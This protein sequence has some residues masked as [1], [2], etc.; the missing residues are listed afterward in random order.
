[1]VSTTAGAITASVFVA[2]Y[3]GH[4]IGDHIVQSDTVMQAK[5]IPSN[6]R[7]AAGANPWTGWAACA[8]HVA[9]YTATQAA[10][11]LLVSLVAPLRLAGVL[12]A[13]VTSAATHAVIDR[14][15]VVAYVI[16]AK[17]CTDW[18]DGPYLL[19]QALHY[20]ALLVAAVLAATITTT[21]AVVATTTAAL[22][23]VA[24]ALCLERWWARTAARRIGDPTRL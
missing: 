12:A 11:V 24:V 2:L 15:W 18:S 4:Q 20:G 22:A 23:L 7:L 5:A 9:S 3:A 14:R 10:A 6:D 16:R 17:K 8:R 1:M 19:D 21:G 13:L